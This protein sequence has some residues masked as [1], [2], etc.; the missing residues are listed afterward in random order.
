MLFL[1]LFQSVVSTGTVHVGTHVEAFRFY[2][3]SSS[4]FFPVSLSNIENVSNDEVFLLKSH[5][6]LL[7]NRKYENIG[8]SCK[9]GRR[10]RLFQMMYVST[11]TT[12]LCSLRVLSG[13]FHRIY[14]GE[15]P[16]S[17]RLLKICYLSSTRRL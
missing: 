6:C 10:R 12:Y 3:I 5:V 4:S 7:S 14:I 11:T 13:C 17:L 15:T 9:Q 2:F 1:L 16:D 8:N